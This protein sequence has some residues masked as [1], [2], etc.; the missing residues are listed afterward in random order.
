[1]IPV[2]NVKGK[3]LPEAYE[4]SLIELYR[5]GERIKT[6]YDNPDD[7]PSVDATVN[8]TIEEPEADPMIY[9]IFPG[10]I[11]DLREYVMEL[12]GAKDHWVKNMNDPE[13]KRW[14]YTYHQRL[15]A[16]GTWKESNKIVSITRP[17]NQF[18][19]MIKKLIDAPYT[20]RAQAVTWMPSLDNI[21]YDPPCLQ[22]IWC[23]LTDELD[24]TLALNAN[25]RFRSNDAWGAAFMN[26]FGL[27]MLIRLEI[28]NP[29]E[30]SLGKPVK[31]GRINWQADSY[32]VYGKDIKALVQRVINNFKPLT[33]KV[34]YF[35]SPEVQEIWKEASSKI[36]DKIRKYDEEHSLG[37]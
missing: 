9:K 12:Q 33:E 13:D 36:K 20:R 22:S 19:A 35:Y 31:L 28:A 34:Y 1:M 24:G 3:T 25:I 4:N 30:E 16:W 11:E 15:V 27:T 26:M 23:R 5:S 37:E 8:I 14:E 21:V 32:H 17:V 7:L 6:Q 29:V 10:G 2:L 18:Q